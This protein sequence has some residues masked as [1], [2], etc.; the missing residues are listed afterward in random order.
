MEFPLA[1]N[2]IIIAITKKLYAQNTST[3]PLFLILRAHKKTTVRI[4]DTVK[5]E[6]R[7]CKKY[8]LIQLIFL[9]GFVTNTNK[10]KKRIW[11]R[12]ILKSS[13]KA[14]TSV[15]EIGAT[16]LH[17]DM[18]NHCYFLLYL[19]EQF[20]ARTTENLMFCLPTISKFVFG[21][22]AV[23]VLQCWI[24]VN[25]Q[26]DSNVVITYDFNDHTFNEANGLVKA[27][28][29]GVTLVEDRFGND[30]SATFINGHQNS[31]LNL[32]VSPLL[33]P[34]NAT[35]SIW[36]NLSRRVY[37]GKGYDFNPII[38]LKNGPGVDFIN[39]YVIS[40]D[41][42][43][44]RFS[45]SASRDSLK[46]T[47]VMSA[48]EP[49]F[50]KWYHFV[51]TSNYD[52]F[53]FYING[54]L[55]GRCRKDF[56]TKFLETDSFMVGHTASKKNERFSQG[57]FDDIKIFHRV[58]S[59]KE[60]KALYNAPNPN[61]S[62]VFWT[63]V[64]EVLAI[65][66]GIF[67]IAFLLV[68]RRR[69]ALLRTQERLETK[70]KLH[71]MEIRTLKAQMNPHF[72]F[73]SLNSIQQFIMSKENDKAELYLS[74]FSKLIRELLESNTNESLTINEEVEII[75]GYLDME[76]LRFSGVFSFSIVVDNAVDQENALIPHMMVQPFIENAIW[77]GLLTKQGERRVDVF[78]EK[79]G[80]RMIRCII[81]DNGIGRQ[82]ATKKESTFKRKSLAL[83]FVKQR[84]ELLKETLN[85][86]CGVSIIDKVDENKNSIGTKVIVLLPT[87]DK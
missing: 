67:V 83:S 24:G 19:F 20:R 44:K 81:D 63:T 57:I 79:A 76:S 27:R 68:W 12:E 4:A 50:G 8:K 58:L 40:Y 41:C 43:S 70:R 48:N 85:V 23:F 53:A 30:A 60:I 11:K 31:Y 74:K 28:P 66:T 54:R 51:I 6:K 22:T 62:K 64:L 15:L 69:V 16:I 33:R 77:H 87:I 61:K 59:E 56:E 1:N 42:Y 78:F 80:N 82:N 10:S 3:I 39:A 2:Q 13:W 71:E 47:G 32:G 18:V 34:K 38:Q 29:V 52:Y 37:A 9:K 86:D 5:I 35:I 26:V 45:S 46:E 65:V 7:G 72:I 84:L 75:K 73:N 55:Q 14:R 49:E 21:L 17:S 36:V 25:A